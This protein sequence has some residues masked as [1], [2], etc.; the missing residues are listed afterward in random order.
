MLLLSGACE[1]EQPI[2]AESGP[3]LG[4]VKPVL[5]VRDVEASAPFFR[6][7]LGFDFLEYA[8]IEGEPYYAEMAAGGMKFGL[9]HPMN[10]EQEKWIGHQRIY[11]RVRNVREHRESVLS[12]GGSAGEIVKTEWM[13][14][15]MVRDLD[16]HEIVFAETDPETHSIDPW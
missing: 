5:Y 12:R 7:I 9:H 6:D 14:M 15:F 10:A 3:F 11:F 8:E 4:Q 2:E 13:D 16:G 1:H